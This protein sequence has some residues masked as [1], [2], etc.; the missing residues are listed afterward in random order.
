MQTL[1]CHTG[2]LVKDPDNGNWT[3]DVEVAIE[4]T[5][6]GTI[7]VNFYSLSVP[8]YDGMDEVEAG[9]MLQELARKM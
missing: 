6:G 5:D 2:S 3:S 7:T 1:C 9:L 8:D 4:N